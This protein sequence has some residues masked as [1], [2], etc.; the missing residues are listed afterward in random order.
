MDNSILG[1]YTQSLLI[2]KHASNATR[3]VYRREAACFLSYLEERNLDYADVDT[4]QLKDFLIWRAEG[5]ES[6]EPVSG[7]TMSRVITVLR[8]FFSYLMNERIREDDPT[9]LLPK[10]KTPK[11]LPATID[12][13]SVQKILDVIDTSTDLGFRDRTMFELIYSCGLRVSECANLRVT[14]YY[15]TERRLVVLGK[16][17]KERMIPVG[18]VAA[19]LLETYLSSVRPRLL[20]RAKSPYM[21][22]SQEQK[23]ITRQE[24]WVRLKKYCETAGVDSKVHTLRHSFATHML[25]NGADL[26]SV[27]ELLGHSDIRTT[28]IY[29][30]VDTDDLFRAFEAGHPDEKK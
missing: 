18:D 2:E 15:S 10:N 7:R 28:E 22:I 3:D 30:H 6:G 11:K 1:D 26:R 12:Y 27:Q 23:V 13:D 14:R 9:E 17:S 5:G 20:G 21:F 19:S 24:I 29:T 16:G 25:K 8:S 4:A